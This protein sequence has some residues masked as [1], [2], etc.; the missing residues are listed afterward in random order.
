MLKTPK[1]VSENKESQMQ[2]LEK[3]NNISV[4]IVDNFAYW[5]QDNVLFKAN[6]DEN[7]VIDFETKTPVDVMSM[8]KKELNSIVNIVD[9][10]NNL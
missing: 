5:A 8:S 9:S 2:K 4:A 1:I 3:E 7:G 10:I 6:L